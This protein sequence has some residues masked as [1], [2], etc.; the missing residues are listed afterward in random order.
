MTP[1]TSQYAHYGGGVYFTSLHPGSGKSV[2]ARNNYRRG[3]ATMENNGRIDYYIQEDFDAN[4]QNIEE[5][6]EF[7]RDIYLYRD[8]DVVLSKYRHR[9]GQTPWNDL[10]NASVFLHI[11]LYWD[12]SS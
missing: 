10:I 8:N 6:G 12:N 4:D 1:R 5:V 9:F 2:I 7:Q 11:I 3:A